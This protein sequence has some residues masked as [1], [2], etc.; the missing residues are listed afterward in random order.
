MSFWN[1]I[2]YPKR[3]SDQDD[4]WQFN[5]ILFFMLVVKLN[6]FSTFNANDL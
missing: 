1:A 3:Y 4:I 6:N 2:Y 5:H